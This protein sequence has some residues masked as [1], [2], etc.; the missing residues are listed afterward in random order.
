VINLLTWTCFVTSLRT[1]STI[2]RSYTNVSAGYTAAIHDAIESS[3]GP[4]CLA[5]TG[6]HVH[7]PL[8]AFPPP[9]FPHQ[10]NILKTRSVILANQHHWPLI[11]MPPKHK[12]VTNR[13]QH[14]HTIYQTAPIHALRLHGRRQREEGKDVDQQQEQHRDDVAGEPRAA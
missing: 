12:I 8:R 6:G 1:D 4:G 10:A 13:K 5:L 3:N 11:S 2:G 7:I 14:H 9:S